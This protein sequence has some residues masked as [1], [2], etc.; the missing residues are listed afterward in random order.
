MQT[1]VEWLEEHLQ[2]CMKNYYP[3]SGFV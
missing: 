3:I 2:K 1:A